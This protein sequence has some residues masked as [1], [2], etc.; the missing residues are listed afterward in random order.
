MAVVF[1]R[2]NGLDIMRKLF[3]CYKLRTMYSYTPSV[4]THEVQLSSV[5]P[6]GRRLRRWKLDE[7]P[8]LWN[9]LRGDMSL[10]GPRPCLPIQSELIEKRR[11]MGVLDFRPG[12]TGLAQ[13]AGVDMSD[14]ERLA[15]IDS[16][17]RAETK[18]YR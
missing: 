6:I 10:V 12:I 1:L 13:V 15:N 8:H 16:R 14:P 17:I 18:F 2:S 4:G 3:T 9:V 5:T 11:Q 7:L